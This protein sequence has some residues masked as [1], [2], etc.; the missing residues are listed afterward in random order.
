MRPYL[1]LC[2]MLGIL[3]CDPYHSRECS[4]F[5]YDYNS[6]QTI[7]ET[8]T[9]RFVAEDDEVLTFILEEQ[10]FSE[11]GSQG[12]LGGNCCKN[13]PE[14]VICRMTGNFFY[15]CPEL[16]IDWNQSFVQKESFEQASE[17]QEAEIIL[18]IK[19][20]EEVEYLPIHS[21]QI[22]ANLLAQHTNQTVFD[23]LTINNQMYAEVI[24]IKV[25]SRT[26]TSDLELTFIELTASRGKGIVKLVDRNGKAYFLQE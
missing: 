10:N 4:A 15:H 21:F 1:L 20:R 13:E 19:A 3:G 26:T 6:W 12:Y 5:Y 17:D 11:A 25:D 14:T 24:Q 2:L 22:A 18:R 7:G 23:S 9:I 8:D 16:G